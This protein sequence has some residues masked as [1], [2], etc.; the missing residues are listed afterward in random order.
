MLATDLDADAA[1]HTVASIRAQ[2]HRADA[3]A[4]DVTRDDSVDTLLEALPA[5]VDVLVNN[6]GLQHVARPGGLS[7]G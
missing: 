3:L 4:L 2:G 6:A 7:H 1:G 5:P